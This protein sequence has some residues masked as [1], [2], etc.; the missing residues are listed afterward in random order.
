[1]SSNLCMSARVELDS[2]RPAQLPYR[3]D[4][5]GRGGRGVGVVVDEVSSTAP[6]PTNR[7]TPPL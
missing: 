6:R 3:R 2:G 7:A 4:S 5:G 1:M